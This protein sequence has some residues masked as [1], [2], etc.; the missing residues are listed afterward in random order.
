MGGLL[1][2]RGERPWLY[3]PSTRGEWALYVNIAGGYDLD[4][5]RPEP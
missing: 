5:Q 4:L 2:A 3:G 1:Y